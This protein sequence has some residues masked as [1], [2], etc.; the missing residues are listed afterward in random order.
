MAETKGPDSV[1][2]LKKD[3][4]KSKCRRWQPCVS[5]GLNPRKGSTQSVKPADGAHL[6]LPHLII[7]LLMDDL[8][9]D[10]VITESTSQ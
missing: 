4:S 9:E 2:Q 8:L 10:S 3:N 1:I 6:H 7:S 5:V